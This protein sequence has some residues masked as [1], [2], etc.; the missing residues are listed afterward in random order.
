VSNTLAS[1]LWLVR[2]LLLLA[3]HGV[4]G[5]DVQGGMAACR[6]YTPLCVTGATGASPG[7][8]PGVDPVADTSLGAGPPDSTRL[9]AQPD[10]YALL[11]VHLLEGGRWLPVQARGSTTVTAFALRLGDGTTRVVLVNP[12]PKF[13]ATI[14]IRGVRGGP[15]LLR[16]TGPSIDAT[17][18]ISF[19]GSSVQADGSWRPAGGP[20]A[21][22]GAP[23][24]VTPA[25]AAVA[26]FPAG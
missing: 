7:T 10:Y 26:T 9:A 22:A 19:G 15:T 18:G 3:G 16:L 24:A 11:L 23:I 4:A 1:A 8:A 13:A 5:V 2:Y 25:S 14:T 20:A 12:D 21:A 17:T 6:G